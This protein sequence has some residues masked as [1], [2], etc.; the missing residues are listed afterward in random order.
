[1]PESATDADLIGPSTQQIRH[2]ALYLAPVLVG[3]VLPIISL[4]LL[5]RVV[6]KEEYGAWALAGVYA[7]FATAVA[8][9]GLPV[10][11]ERNFFEQSTPRDR[12][13]L[14]YSIVGFVSLASLLVGVATWVERERLAALF[15]GS[16]EHGW[17]VFWTFCASAVVGIKAYYLT[18]FRNAGDARAFVRYTIDENVA[19]VLLSLVLVIVMR[20]GVI[21][22][23]LG[24]LAASSFVLGLV[25]R[26]GF[27]FGPV[28]FRAGLICGALQT[29]YPLTPRIALKLIAGNVDKYIVGLLSSVGGVGVYA[30]GQRLAYAVF[31]FTTALEN[32][33][34]PQVYR[35]MFAEGRGGADA[36][37]TYLTPFLYASVGSA[38]LLTA[39]AR[40]GIAVLTPAG[41][42]GATPVVALLSMY[43]AA[44]FFG[45]I[46]QLMFARQTLLL[47]AHGVLSLALNVAC[48]LALT[49]MWGA[50]GAAAGTLVAGLASTATYMMLGHR[51]YPIRWRYRS[52]IGMYGFLAAAVI[53]VLL[54]ERLGASRWSGLAVRAALVAGYGWLGVGLGVLSRDNL[55]LVLRSLSQR[56]GGRVQAV[57]S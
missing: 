39:A 42:R 47:S 56:F 48:C 52:L 35:R 54:E 28:S 45:K 13:A 26:R 12:C 19:G 17:L 40:D 20:V 6:S 57:R 7:T 44:L 38:L 46:P 11:Y 9:L 50:P 5:T 29:S 43:Y 21:G 37:G 15:I 22:L 14:L 41:Y 4:P 34:A 3:A 23:A 16:P 49:R 36:V 33:F 18:Y 1:L 53:V 8:G 32:V 10:V 30:I 25:V 51:F 2:S 55:R 27:S 31:V 24:H